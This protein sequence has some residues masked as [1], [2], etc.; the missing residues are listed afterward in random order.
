MIFSLLSYLGPPLLLVVAGVMVYRKL[1]REFP[2]FFTYLIVVVLAELIR[3]VVFHMKPGL[4]YFYSYW[5]SEAVE[6]MLGFLVLYEVFLIRLFP[7]FNITVIYR[8]LFPVMGI[9]VLGL[10]V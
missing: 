3:F 4:A 1:Y 5:T 9:I 10:T 8:R 7:G 2:F 6:V